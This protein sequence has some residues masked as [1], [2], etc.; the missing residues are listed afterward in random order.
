[1]GERSLDRLFLRYRSKGDAKALGELF[2]RAAPE[3][4]KL[5]MHL[6][7]DPGEA[8]DVLQATFLAAIEGA[9]SFDAS[10]P[11]LP[12]LTGILARQAGLVRRRARRVIEPDRLTERESVDPAESAAL[13][14]FSEELA[15]ALQA[16]P[17]NYREVLW[18]HLADGKRP[19]EIAQDLNRAPGTVRMQ[20]HRGLDLLRRALPAGYAAGAGILGATRGLAAVRGEVLAGAATRWRPAPP[21]SG[22][23]YAPGSIAGAIGASSVALKASLAV[24]IIAALASGLWWQQRAARVEHAAVADAQSST[25]AE[26]DKA[27]TLNSSNLR[28]GIADAEIAAAQ[29][30]SADA[31]QTAILVRGHVRGCSTEE[32]ADVSL[33]VSGV[34]R[35]ALP[36]ELEVRGR[37]APDGSFELDVTRLF[38]AAK[39]KRPI[40]ELVLEVDHPRYAREVLHIPALGPPDSGVNASESDSNYSADIEL[41]AAGRVT[42][43]VLEPNGGSAAV[44][45][46]APAAIVALYALVRQTPSDSPVDRDVVAADGTFALRSRIAGEHVVLLLAEGMRPSTTAVSLAP[47]LTVPLG[48][49]VLDEGALIE[50]QALQL[51]VPMGAGALVSASSMS[52]SVGFALEGSRL[53]WTAGAFERKG[54]IVE[55][56]SDGRFRIGGLAPGSYQLGVSRAAPEGALATQ[57]RLLLSTAAWPSIH[58]PARDVEINASFATVH[59]QLHAQNESDNA[60]AKSALVRW[61]QG[62]SACRFSLAFG[63]QSSVSVEPGVACRVEVEAEGFLGQTITLDAPQAGSVST[64]TVVLEKDP[65]LAQLSV[66]IRRPADAGGAP[67]TEAT[68]QFTPDRLL[69]ARAATFVRHAIADDGVFRLAELPAGDWT[70]RAF[71]GGVYEHNRDCWCEAKFSVRL[72]AASAVSSVVTLERGGQLQIGAL[73]SAGSFVAAQCT[74]RPLGGE[75]LDVEFVGRGPKHSV[76]DRWVLSQ[77]GS[78]DVRPNLRAGKYEINLAAKGHEPARLELE[79]VP[80][81]RVKVRALLL[82]SKPPR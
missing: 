79:I 14:E 51:G 47:S 55:T 35:F 41:S 64:Q 6:V 2:D 16:L 40:E 44:N 12:W 52:T 10:R 60:A 29:T 31:V 28:R 18:L 24:L 57:R 8:E 20:V 37:P 70:V 72:S 75:T 36:A 63:E 65:A 58:A 19:I 21:A 33:R 68:F 23:P 56:D 69:G 74:L 25:R 43:R 38:Q 42:G 54:R 82:E 1:M 3:L 48:P 80:G 76:V 50:G 66:E 53:A 62:L 9:D 71:A 77:L 30:Q 17:D 5:S 22:A 39:P 15:L 73:N 81:A 32:L 61:N 13:R 7:R 49:I 45:G 59:L 11:L 78:C 26:S 34:A 67:C 46:A 4:L 27:A